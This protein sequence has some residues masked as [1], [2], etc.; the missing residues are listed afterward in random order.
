VFVHYAPQHKFHE[1]IHNEADIDAA[2]VVWALDLGEEEN[3]KLMAYYPDR[4]VWMVEPDAQPPRL[5]TLSY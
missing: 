4:H 1:W 3:N 5:R 2:R